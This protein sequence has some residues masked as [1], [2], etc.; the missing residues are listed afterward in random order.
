MEVITTHVNADFDAMASM[1]AAKKL[2]P[3]ALLVFS[4]SQ[5]R[6]LR[7][8]FI[9]STLYLYN[10][11]RLRD[12]DLE[13]VHRLILVDTRQAS[14]IARFDQ[15]VNRKGVEVHIY[16][17][18]P[19]SPDDI[20]G[21]HVV[22]RPVGA[23]VTILT[24]LIRERGLDLTPEEATILSLGIFEDTG[25][26]TFNSTTAEDFEAAAYLRRAGADLNVVSDMVTQELT[27]EQVSLLNELLLSARNYNIKGIEVCIATV[28]V[29]NYVGDFALLVHKLKDI[30]NLDVVF[31][32]ARMEDRIYLVARSRLSH[33]NAGAIARQ[34][35]GGGHATAASA[36]IRDLTLIQ[37]EERLMEILNAS[38][39]IYPTAEALMTSPVVFADV[40]M[41]IHDAEQIMVRYNINSMPVLQAGELVGLIT[42]QVLEKA[43]FHKL[44]GQAVGEF[45]TSDFGTV[46]PNAGLLEIQTYLVEHQQRIL[47]V[48]EEG[49]ILGVI[50]RKDLLNFLVND[51][52]ESAEPHLPEMGGS[53][54]PKRKNISGIVK[55]QLDPEIIQVLKDLGEFAEHMGYKAYAI[56]GFV[57]DLI[58]RR[59][60]LDMDIVI[61]GDGIEFAKAFAE[62]RGIRARCH[63]KF[64]TAV[65]VFSER[66]KVDVA[67]A[68]FEYYQHPGALPV[69]EAS[70]LRM[71]LYRRDFTINTL[72]LS[73]NPGDFGHLIDFFGGQRDL[74]EKTIRVL[75]NLSFVEDPTRIMR[76][77]RFEQRFG[78]RIGKQT[79]N[80]MRGA[81][82]MGLVHKLGGRRFFHEIQLILMEENPLPA[83]QRMAEYGVLSVLSNY[84]QFDAKRREIFNAIGNVISWYRLSFLDE[85]LESWRVYAMGLFCDLPRADLDGIWERLDFPPTQS[86][87]MVWTFRRVEKLLR[88]FFQL[89]DHRPSDIY[90]ALQ[91]FNPE[92]IL[93]M[94][95][96]TSSERVR[97]AISHYLHRYRNV[98]TELRG[99]D[100]KA[101]GIPPGP[102]YRAILDELLDAQ[103]NGEVKSRQDELALLSKNHPELVGAPLEQESHGATGS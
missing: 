43:I 12:I 44:E 91:D 65:L 78:F 27:A 90:R 100:L 36:T 46:G 67:S 37:V 85:P 5:E 101:M 11:R 77:I 24:Q 47:P 29:D 33:V 60:N 25:S 2:Y 35:G 21:D 18:H 6:T 62:K 98:Q 4:G 3:E 20:P 7:E 32:L 84:L 17:H 50:T 56:G 97:R 69:V 68:R 83:L 61:E 95:A 79:A 89:P 96:K 30:N 72:A 39:R 22:V 49:R 54:W 75:H 40:H 45:M 58:L 53:R 76:A 1:I 55:E 93:F 80:L 66:L 8:F 99:R 103:I 51:Q 57:R 87:R 71:D 15:I 64:N 16:D 81:V 94:M 42:R 10:F 9:K 26:F 92:E 28:S 23:T 73:I 38:I 102:V 31:A 74:K 88:G 63:K 82:K 70:S 19:D 41:P 59:P 48:V 86:R 34:F 13:E 52:E 14:R